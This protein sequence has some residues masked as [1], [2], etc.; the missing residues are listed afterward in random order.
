MSRL[1]QL[2]FEADLGR[3]HPLL[4]TCIIDMRLSA[5]TGKRQNILPEALFLLYE[6]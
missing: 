2:E 3:G 5:A 6:L 4:S 1:L